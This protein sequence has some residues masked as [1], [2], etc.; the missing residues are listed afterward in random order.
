VSITIT[1]ILGMRKAKI[2]NVILFLYKCIYLLDT[3]KAFDTIQYP[4]MLKVL[5][6]S[7]IH[8]A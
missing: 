4:F 1:A 8:G 5:E 7:G 3:E 6:R 2:L